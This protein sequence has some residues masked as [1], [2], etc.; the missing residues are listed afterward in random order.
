MSVTTYP[1][2]R[3]ALQ[4]DRIW[5]PV[6]FLLLSA[7]ALIFP[8]GAFTVDEAI[9]VEMARAMAETGSFAIAGTGGVEDGPALLRRFTHDVGGL[10]MPQY[11]SG[12]AIVAAPFYM[13]LGLN[14]LILLNALSAGVCVWLT[15]RLGRLLYG[16]DKVAVTAAVLFAG[17]TFMTTYAFGI[18]PHM[19]TLA[20]LL[21][22]IERVVTGLERERMAW[23]AVG[24]GLF[25][26]AVTLRVDA[27]LAILAVF[28]WLR[29]FAA[30]DRRS[31]ALIYCAGLLPGLLGASLINQAKF[32][33]FLPIA[34][35]PA[36]QDNHADPY[37]PYIGV[38][39]FAL[40]AV[41]FLNVRQH[42]AQALIAR[43]TQPPVSLALA[44]LGVIAIVLVA[45]L[46]DWVGNTGVLLFDLQQIDVTRSSDVMTYGAGGL[47]SFWGLNKTALFQSVPFAI[48]ALFMLE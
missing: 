41:S 43:V 17:A 31:V 40:L 16:D 30:P 19:L 29:L 6:L 14:G 47:K 1:M 34:Y 4:L 45:P 11:P 2:G 9:Y 7:V 27:I 23:V 20:V 10:A 32:D 3:S 5:L 33:L 39:L 22:G 44:G 15:R 38:A 21:G 48:M 18:W 12:Y 8:A 26:I 28:V 25:G 13:A 36:G 46:R 42:W 24:A 35:G 37:L